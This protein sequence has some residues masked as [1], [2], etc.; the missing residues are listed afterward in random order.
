[1][2][3]INLFAAVAE[4]AGKLGSLYRGNRLGRY[5]IL[6]FMDVNGWF[7]VNAVIKD[8]I[9]LIEEDDFEKFKKPLTLWLSAYR[10]PGHEKITLMLNHFREEYP[11]TCRLYRKFVYDNQSENEPSSWQL[12]DFIFSEIDRD[13]TDYDEIELEKLIRRAS[14]GTTLKAARIFA[15]FLRVLDLKWAYNFESRENPALI[16]DAYSI[17]DFAV[18]AYCIFNEDAWD[19]HNLLEKAAHSKQYANL[20]LFTALHFISALRKGDMK[21]LPAP[22]LPYDGKAVLENILNGSFTKSEAGALVDEFR[23]RLKLQPL[24]P[25]KTSAYDKIPD[26]KLF[27]PESLKAPLGIIMA[28][29]LSH[30]SEI[31]AGDCF[32][33]PSDRLSNI[34]DFFGKDFTKAL[35]NR[36]FS[37]RRSN[38][39]YLQGI[40]YSADSYD[41]PGKP[42]GYMLAALARS[43]KSGIGRLAEITDIYLKDAK[44]TGYTPEFI[45]REMFERGVFSFIPAVLLE[46]YA[47]DKYKILPVESQTKLIGEIGIA[48]HQIEW[49]TGAVER[50]FAK[51]RVTVNSILQNPRNVGEILQNIASGNA[52]SR[53]DDC[54]CLMTAAGLPCPYA[55]RD[56]CIGCGYEIYTKTAIHTLMGEYIRLSELK[57]SSGQTE[58]RRY[59][60]I[61]EQAVL[62]AISEI[63]CTAKHFYK[64]NDM[65]EIL[66]IVERGVE[67]ADRFL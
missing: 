32:V 24:K 48:S 20:W 56:S 8:K 37:S 23:T 27:V 61:L 33:S 50:A 26:L 6:E 5:D 46:I 17:N 11:E 41:T 54:L 53:H 55:D 43:H 12:L 34:R 44:F 59:E 58:S 49:V 60:K 15:E 1:M 66:D 45:I 13:I 47:G 3:N 21:R 42:K 2:N 9:P 39:S 28:V 65:T 51:S 35:G 22:N 14:T 64:E 30:R 57:K 31:R 36:R 40:E 16:N 18:M 38:K 10:K 67:Y 63:L 29:S 19:K 25:S 62:P 4:M 52:P 7:G